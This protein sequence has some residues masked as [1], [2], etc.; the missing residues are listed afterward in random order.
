LVWLDLIYFADVI[1]HAD[2]RM[3]AARR[4]IVQPYFY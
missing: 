3:I 1:V 2:I 4:L